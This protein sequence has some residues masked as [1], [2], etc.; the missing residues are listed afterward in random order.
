MI[1]KT[2]AEL[3][4]AQMTWESTGRSKKNVCIIIG[5][6]EAVNGTMQIIGSPNFKKACKIAELLTQ[7]YKQDYTVFDFTNYPDCW[8]RRY[9]FR[10]AR[11]S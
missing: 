2:K 8:H 5:H 9:G 1:D 4:I 7:Q 10:D 6:T 11:N 3:L